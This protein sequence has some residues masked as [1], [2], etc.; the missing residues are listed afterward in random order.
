MCNFNTNIS[1][2]WGQ[3]PWSWHI[4]IHSLVYSVPHILTSCGL[5]VYLTVYS[6]HS[7]HVVRIGSSDELRRKRKKVEEC[8]RVWSFWGRWLKLVCFALMNTSPQISEDRVPMISRGA[9]GQWKAEVTEGGGRVRR[10]YSM[11]YSN[12]GVAPSACRG[13]IL[14]Q[15]VHRIIWK[16]QEDNRGNYRGQGEWQRIAE[17]NRIKLLMTDQRCHHKRLTI[18]RTKARGN[19]TGWKEI[20]AGD[21]GEHSY[22]K[23]KRFSTLKSGEDNSAVEEWPRVWKSAEELLQ[24]CGVMGSW[25]MSTVSHHILKDF[26]CI[27][28]SGK[29]WWKDNPL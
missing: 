7:R 5:T 14:W 20:V 21:K 25:H 22:Y 11:Q 29:L 26:Y 4:H 12:W 6:S 19:I 2:S 27:F 24:G 28:P 23:W 13:Y 8:T 10:K 16:E 9:E 18:I 15:W 17:Q 1:Y 3:S